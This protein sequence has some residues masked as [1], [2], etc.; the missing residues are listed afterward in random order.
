[1]DSNSHHRRIISNFV[2]PS[3]ADCGESSRPV[4]DFFECN[5][6][7]WCTSHCRESCA[8]TEAQNVRKLM[9]VDTVVKMYCIT[10]SESQNVTVAL[11]SAWGHAPTAKSWRATVVT[12]SID[13][14]VNAT[15]AL[16]QSSWHIWVPW[17]FWVVYLDSRFQSMVW[18]EDYLKHSINPALYQK[19]FQRQTRIT[20]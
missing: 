18:I 15:T 7:R 16:P 11:S 6:R 17:Q 20:P 13:M 12:R 14:F 19:H 10:K 4:R 5:D 1:M 9:T 3:S 8:D 2:M